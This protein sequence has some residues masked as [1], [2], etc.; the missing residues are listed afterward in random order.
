MAR[1]DQ[2]KQQQRLPGVALQALT[3]VLHKAVELRQVVY[4]PA[5]YTQP[6]AQRQQRLAGDGQWFAAAVVEAEAHGWRDG[7]DFRGVGP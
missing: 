2:R 3:R 7:L 4:R 1:V 6:L 5:F